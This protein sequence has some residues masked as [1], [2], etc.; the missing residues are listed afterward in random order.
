MKRT[1]ARWWRRLRHR[2]TATRDRPT[3]DSDSRQTTPR[4]GDAGAPPAEHVPGHDP[5]APDEPV[6]VRPVGASKWHLLSAGCAPRTHPVTRFDGRCPPRAGGYVICLGCGFDAGIGAE[7]ATYIPT[8]TPDR[9]PAVVPGP[10]TS[11]DA[12]SPGSRYLPG[13]STPT[14]EPTALAA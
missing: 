8:P 5:A 11:K 7:A 12:E 4:H 13:L 10:R 9:V 3:R 14:P 1:T 2:W 6:W